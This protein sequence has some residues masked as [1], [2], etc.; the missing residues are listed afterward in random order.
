[1]L[2]PETHRHRTSA[3]DERWLQLLDASAAVFST[4]GY[5]KASMR[6]IAA[7]AQ[8]SLSGIYHYVAGKEELLY[9]IQYDTFASLLQG[10]ERSLQGVADPRERLHVAVRVPQMA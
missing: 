4:Q 5:D 9:W 8:L 2:H 6:Q 7:E 1:M 3:F 10:L